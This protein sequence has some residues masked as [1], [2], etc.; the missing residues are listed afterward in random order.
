[1]C[2][3]VL[4]V[5]GPPDVGKSTIAE[6]LATR[7]EHG[8]HLESDCFFDFIRSGYIEPWRPE[9]HHQNE[10]VMGVAALAAGAYADAGYLAVI[11]G[12]VSPRWFFRPLRDT[13]RASGHRVA[14]LVLR[15]PLAVCAERA[16]ARESGLRASPAIEQLWNDFAD[17]GDL[18]RHV[19]EN[20]RKAASE[21]ADQATQVLQD[22]D[23]DL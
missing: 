16:R 17:L 20:D 3:R 2:T 7:A 8:V 18:E 19:M 12:I 13:L 6:M 22:G 21:V 1:M 10:I 5:T 14:Y 23:L 4:I 15:A 9:S 11:D